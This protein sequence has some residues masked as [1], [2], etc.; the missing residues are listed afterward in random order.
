MNTE[1][2]MCG[3][4]VEGGVVYKH[5]Q[6]HPECLEWYII[7]INEVDGEGNGHETK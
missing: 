4:R 1:C 3:Q 5:F 6:Y 2:T 7:I